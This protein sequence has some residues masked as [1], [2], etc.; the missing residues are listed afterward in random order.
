[1]LKYSI[2]FFKKKNYY[3]IFQKKKLL[4]ELGESLARLRASYQHSIF[5]RF[6]IFLFQI[7]FIK[8]TFLRSD[9]VG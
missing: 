5:Y 8:V 9:S 2:T 4:L 7:L 6:L 1:M 3:N